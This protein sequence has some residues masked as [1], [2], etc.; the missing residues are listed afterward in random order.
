MAFIKL[1]LAFLVKIILLPSPWPQH[2]LVLDQ[3]SI[4]VPLSVVFLAKNH[5][6]GCQNYFGG[7]G[8]PENCCLL[9]G[10]F[11]FVWGF[12]LTPFCVT[13]RNCCV[14]TSQEYFWNPATVTLFTTDFS[15]FRCSMWSLSECLNMY[16]HCFLFFFFKHCLTATWCALNEWGRS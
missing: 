6:F 2:V 15:P 14:W 3:Q 12:F 11:M 13:S 10:V 8:V 5:L 9:D 4:G 16:L 1:Q 7:K